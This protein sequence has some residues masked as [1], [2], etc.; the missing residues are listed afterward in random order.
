MLLFFTPIIFSQYYS[1]YEQDKFVNELF[2]HNKKNGFFVDIGAHDGRT[3]SNTL[4]F[5]ESLGWRGICFEPLAEPFTKLVANRPN[6]FCYNACVSWQKG[7]QRFFEVQGYS[8]ML[9][10]LV[11][12]YDPRHLERLKKEIKLYGG[13]YRVIVVPVVQFNEIM[14]EKNVQKVDFLSLDTEGSEIEILKTIDFDAVKID[15]IAVENNYLTKDIRDFLILKGYHF[16]IHKG[17]EIYVHS[18]LLQNHR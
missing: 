14:Q 17:D 7:E 3:Y 15:V 10:G 2:F 1:Q 13:S 5:E 6:S 12:T 8:Q 11:D 4:F 18:R 9:S 16:V